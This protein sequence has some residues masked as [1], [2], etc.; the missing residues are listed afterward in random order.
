MSTT[1]T[2]E[3]QR[4]RNRKQES[5]AWGVLWIALGLFFAIIALSSMGVYYFLFR[6]TLPLQSQLEVTRGTLGVTGTDLIEQ[7]VRGDRQPYLSFG[8]IVTVNP[9]SQGLLLID[10]V[11][12]ENAPYVAAVTLRNDTSVT[13]NEAARPRYDW[14]SQPYTLDLTNLIGEVEV[15]ISDR[16]DRAVRIGLSTRS[17]DS[18]ILTS[19]GQ[20]IISARGDQLAISNFQGTAL[21]VTDDRTNSRAVPAGQLGLLTTSSNEIN[22]QAGYVNLLGDRGFREANVVESDSAATT[23]R[24]VTSW[25]CTDPPHDPPRGA[26]AIESFDGR[27]ALHI[28]RGGG[29]ETH[30]ETR[31][32]KY[33]GAGSTGVN[34]AEHN[35]LALHVTFYVVSQSLSVC[36]VAGT[37]CPLML[38]MQYIPQ[39][40]PD[41]EGSTTTTDATANGTSEQSF[42]PIPVED[43]PVRDWHHGFYTV[44]ADQ[45]QSP[46]RCDTCP[47]EHSYIRPG[48][49]FTYDS[50]NLMALFPQEQKP[51]SILSFSFYASGHEYEV[52]VSE[53]A[54]LVD[55]LPESAE[56]AG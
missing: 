23:G 44:P 32:T 54:L 10:D 42:G 29:A 4:V 3:Y 21:L 35:Y 40:T 20:Y 41:T 49:W 9:D 51:G 45:V 48:R 24:T 11:R 55:S 19:P 38:H 13:L 31:C 16:V 14:S 43:L 46:L 5:V 33:F 53:V 12:L 39:L 1:T 15:L 2:R 6:S 7:V 22:L 34:V 36:G 25:I 30:G 28:V 47:Q 8:D 50:G 52:Y 26:Y 37:E 18:A 27:T 17:G 56:P